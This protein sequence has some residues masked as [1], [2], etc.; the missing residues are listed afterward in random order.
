MRAESCLLCVSSILLRLDRLLF[1]ELVSLRPLGVDPILLRLGVGQGT[2]GI[3]LRLDTA[4]RLLVHGLVECF[5]GFCPPQLGGM[6]SF[7]VGLLSG[8]AP[9]LS[10]RFSLGLRVAG[11]SQLSVFLLPGGLL[12]GN[13][14]LLVSISERSVLSGGLLG[15]F[16]SLPGSLLRLRLLGSDACG[17]L[18]HLANSVFAGKSLVVCL[19]LGTIVGLVLVAEALLPGVKER[20]RRRKVIGRAH[21]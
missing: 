10:S 9:F 5:F 16:P 4:D 6:R 12:T 21:R 1:G 15:S 17:L 20:E 3:D 14:L 18:L 19:D 11:S 2:L 7:K 8:L 13:R